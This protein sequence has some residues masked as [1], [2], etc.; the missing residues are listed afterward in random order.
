MKKSLLV[1]TV[2][3]L[4]VFPFYLAAQ[5]RVVHYSEIPNIESLNTVPDVAGMVLMAD[6]QFIP[7]QNS[8]FKDG[9]QVMSGWPVSAAGPTNRGGIY[10]NLDEDPELEI[11][12]NIG[13][14]V[15]AWNID[16][17]DVTG[18]PKSVSSS[19]S[20]GAP[21]YGDIDGDGFE[22]VVVSC[23]TPG[24]GNTGKVYAFERDGSTVTGFPITCAGG[25][26][27]T[28]VL[29]DLEDD[30]TMEIIVELRNWPNGFV[31]VYHGDGTIKEGWPAAMDY[32][33]ASAVAVGDITGDGIPEI[34]AESYYKVWAFG[35]NGD[36][37][38]GFPYTAGADRVF[39]YSSPVI[40]NMDG[41]GP[42]E[43]LVGDHN[44][45]SGNGAVHIIKS[46]GTAYQG[47]PKFVS[48]WIYGPVS[49]ADINSNGILDVAVG[50][51]VLSGSAMD[52][53]YAWDK[54]GTALPGFPIG[55]IWAVNSQIVIADLDGD[56]MFEL[57]FDDNTSSAI[58]NGYNHDGTM[59][60]GWPINV[61]GTSFFINPF[62]TDIDGDGLLNINGGGYDQNGDKSYIYM[63]ENGVP[64]NE[65]KSVLPVL[66]YN[67]RHTGVYGEKGNPSVS[68]KENP[69]IAEM[70]FSCFPNPCKSHTMLHFDL[71]S[72]GN[73]SLSVFDDKGVLLSQTDL[74]KQTAGSHEFLL[75]TSG[76]ENGVYFL[77]I[78]DSLITNMIQRVLVLR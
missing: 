39:S 78:N 45:A 61:T 20:S 32:I 9:V 52:Y 18:W 8:I 5:N 30:G 53:V 1:S 77:Q 75:N 31:S 38:A 3:L 74:G 69:D 48:H 19:P 62:V 60:E 43:I 46:D 55:P 72:A 21:A 35:I 12:Y 47:W 63:W 11:V 65:E 2:S 68:V 14:K 57:M 51:Q 49:V 59:M 7:V 73:I 71:L 67:V 36:T 23:Q 76:F 54:D 16:G 37:I 42:N 66:Q 34:V 29:A 33:P 28:P 40:A 56:N 4:L 58:Y 41:L 50:D 64:Y 10:C 22:E 15:Y 17:S 25:P 70:E 26:T 6:E 24:T 13:N 44:L 27:R